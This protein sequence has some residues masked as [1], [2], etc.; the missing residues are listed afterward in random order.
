MPDK[1]IFSDGTEFECTVQPEPSVHS[2]KA[3]RE[4]KKISISNTTVDAVKIAFVDNVTYEKA[5]DSIRYLSPDEVA[6]YD[7]N[8]I[9]YLVD[10]NEMPY[11]ME[12]YSEDLSDYCVAGDVV[13]CRNGNIVV[14]MGKKTEEEIYQEALDNLMIQ[15]LGGM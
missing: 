8:E 5:W 9:P 15:M 11:I 12:T 2:M 14:Y 4:W 3:Q 1:I 10:E 7:A 13:D 6:Q